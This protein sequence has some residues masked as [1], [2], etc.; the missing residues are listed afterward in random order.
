MNLRCSS[1]LSRFLP[2][3]LVIV[4]IAG[5]TAAES[6]FHTL[7]NKPSPNIHVQVHINSQ[8]HGLT[9][10]ANHPNIQLLSSGN[11]G[12]ET[13][14]VTYTDSENVR[15]FLY[16]DRFERLER[17]SNGTLPDMTRFV[18]ALF[19][20]GKP[21]NVVGNGSQFQYVGCYI[22][23]KIDSKSE[24]ETEMAVMVVEV[25]DSALPSR[26]LFL[27]RVP[28]IKN[29]IENNRNVGSVRYNHAWQ[30]RDMIEISP[31]RRKRVIKA[32]LLEAPYRTTEC[33]LY[34]EGNKI[35]HDR[36]IMLEEPVVKF[37]Y[38]KTNTLRS[39]RCQVN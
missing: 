10:S 39:I 2:Y 31:G 6:Q 14:L 1:L 3:T 27:K 29:H 23:D 35:L 5:L 17:S 28:V 16:G 24:D 7:F 12:I 26:E 13:A 19:W 11:G 8:L 33:F 4:A 9:L 20:H 21:L 30:Q 32:A 15:C 34:S 25:Q 36:A 37:S 22:Y 38:G 18:S